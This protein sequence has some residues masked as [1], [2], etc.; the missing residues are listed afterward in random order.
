MKNLKT[1]TR[2]SMQAA[3]DT[4]E[5]L[6]YEEIGASFWGG[7]VDAK[8]FVLDLKALD[9][10]T[11][12][13]RLNSPG[14]DVFDGV[15]IYNQLTQHPATVNIFIDGL[16]ASIASIIAMAG[17]T[18]SIA[19]NAMLMIHNAWAGTVGNSKDMRKM[20]D[21]LDKIDVTMAGT[22]S[23]RSGTSKSKVVEMMAEETWF[24]GQEAVDAGFA[25]EIT[26]STEAAEA[27][28]YFDLS[29]FK[30]A[31]AAY[32]LLF[33]NSLKSMKDQSAE[34]AKQLPSAPDFYR[35]RLKLYE[36]TL[37]H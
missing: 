20:A 16:A 11:L 17:N 37:K 7:G 14:G 25:D 27:R 28:A 6:I 26:Q 3:G 4:A 9:V 35:E 24:S 23:K 34:S 12:N 18:I 36:R 10:K 32:A 31:P 33:H 8:Q 13:V 19:D 22:Y 5:I 21:I 30:H 15:A 1:G 2:F 29:H